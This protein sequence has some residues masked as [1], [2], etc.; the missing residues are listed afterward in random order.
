MPAEQQDRMNAESERMK[1]ARIDLGA[2]Q[3][4]RLDSLNA[5]DDLRLSSTTIDQ[6]GVEV[7]N[8]MGDDSFP[9]VAEY[10]EEQ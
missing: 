4:Q 2:L 7:R 5:K 9:L 10:A 1:K 3:L 8:T 6:F